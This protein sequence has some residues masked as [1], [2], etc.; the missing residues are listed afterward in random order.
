MARQRKAKPKPPPTVAERVA[1]ALDDPALAALAKLRAGE[2]LT[3]N[4]QRA[5]KRFE[6][7]IGEQLGR[8]LVRSVPQRLY[9][10]W[11]G[12]QTKVL[13]EQAER[14]GLPFAGRAIDLP[15]LVRALHDFLAE[16]G[17]RLVA[18]DEEGMLLAGGESPELER[19]HKFTADLK[20]LELAK[21]RKQLCDVGK[22]R[23]WHD[24][25]AGLWRDFGETL[26]R[27]GDPLALQAFEDVLSAAERLTDDFFDD[28][29]DEHDAPAA[30][31]TS[32]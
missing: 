21:Q 20:E 27:I 29:D 7:S 10:E 30:Q 2:T 11:S 13:H 17:R 32:A 1:A 19:V 28:S 31:A 24:D 8:E 5:I 4:D 22:M 18:Q 25:L 14:Y 16:H 15:A 3:Y 9:R 6:R 26:M 12:R 23:R